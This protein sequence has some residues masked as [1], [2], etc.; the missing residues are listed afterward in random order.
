V[1]VSFEE[2]LAFVAPNARRATDVAAR[3]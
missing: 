3:A 2:A 1:L